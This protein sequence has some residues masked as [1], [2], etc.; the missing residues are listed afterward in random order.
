VPGSKPLRNIET[1]IQSSLFDATAILGRCP[2]EELFFWCKC[3]L[4]RAFQ[5][6]PDPA[7]SGPGGIPVLGDWSAPRRLE[8]EC[9]ARCKAGTGCCAARDAES[10]TRKNRPFPGRE[11]AGLIC[12]VVEHEREPPRSRSTARSPVLR[13]CAARRGG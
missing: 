1:D 5:N 2:G 4:V 9:F 7:T 12:R 10:S 13:G 6:R 3:R 8:Q 11:P